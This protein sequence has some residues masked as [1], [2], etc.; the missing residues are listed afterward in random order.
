[1]LDRR[2]RKLCHRRRSA[3]FIA[4]ALVA[5]QNGANIVRVHDV[6]ATCDALAIWQAVE[7]SNLTART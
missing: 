5:V 7:R 3:R 4:A 1:M 6:G 2:T